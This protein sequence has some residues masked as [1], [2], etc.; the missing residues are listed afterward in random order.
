MSYRACRAALLHLAAEIEQRSGDERWVV[1]IGDVFSAG[2]RRREAC[3]E[4][5]LS[6]GSERETEVALDVLRQAVREVA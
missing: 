1:T 3:V 4:L 5:E 2:H 6:G